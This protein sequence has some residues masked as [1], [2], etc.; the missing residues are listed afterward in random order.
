MVSA[1]MNNA[2]AVLQLPVIHVIKMASAWQVQVKRCGCGLGGVVR[3]MPAYFH[4]SV[5]T[6][7]YH[8][9]PNTF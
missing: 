8:R 5:I 7:D 9:I 6:T 4:G 3:S 1:G 2:G